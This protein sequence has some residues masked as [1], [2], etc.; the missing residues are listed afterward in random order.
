MRR[1]RAPLRGRARFS[2]RAPGCGRDPFL[3][4]VAPHHT[5]LFPLVLS[6]P[7]PVFP[8]SLLT[9]GEDVRVCVLAKTVSVCAC[10]CVLAK[11]VSV[12]V[13]VWMLAQV[14][15]HSTGEPSR[16]DSRARHLVFINYPDKLP[17]SAKTSVS[18]FSRM[19]LEA[20]IEARFGTAHRVL[21]P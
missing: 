9:N 21:S 7:R 8:P 18:V 17:G 12:C 14:C 2:A 20:S 3:R 13:R 4:N 10:V 6:P 11:T 16:S 5:A 1:K 15:G 19:L